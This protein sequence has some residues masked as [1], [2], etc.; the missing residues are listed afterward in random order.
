MHCFLTRPLAGSILCTALALMA[1]MAQGQSG[2]A[3]LS[4]VVSTTTGP[5]EFA[6]IT[7]H[8]AADSAVVK[9][10]FSDP[11]GRFQLLVPT[12][13]RY[14]VSVSQVGY[15]R[16][17]QGPLALGNVPLSPLEF[18]LEAGTA[19]QLRGV[20][21]AGQ[22]PLYERLPDRTVVN[23]E[24]SVLS[25]GNTTLD[26]LGRAPGV[27][28]DAND[29]LALR[30]RQGLLVLVDGKRVPLTGTELAAMLRA[31]PAEQVA[32]VE[33]ITNPPAKYDAQGGAGIIAINLKKDQR[34]GLNGSANA[35]YGRG[36]YGKFSSGLN[37]NYRRKHVNLYGSYAYADRQTWQR[38]TIDRTYLEDNRAA[39]YLEQA[40]TTRGHLQSHTWRGG[41]DVAVSSRTNLGLLVSGLVSRLPSDGQNESRVF[42]G[43][44]QLADIVVAQNQR[45]L[46][47]PNVTANVLLRHLFPKDSLGT[48]VLTVDTDAGRYQLTRTLDLVATPILRSTPTVSRL[49]GDQHGTL[50]LLSAK[51]DYVRNLRRGIRLETGLK[52]SRV[53]SR[54]DVLFER[55]LNGAPT[56]P[57]ATLSNQFRYEEAIRA[58]YLTLSRSRPQLSIS[59]GLRAEYTSTLG[60]QAVSNQQFSR[61]YFQLFPSVN[62]QRP[63]NE[64]HQLA[65]SLSRRL[66]RPTYNQLNPFRSYVDP[67]SY[68]VGNPALWPQISTQAEVTHTFRQQTTTALRYTHTRRPILGVYLLDADGLIAATDVNLSSQDY[69]GLTVASPFAPTAWW[70]LYANAEVF[71]IRFRGRLQGSALPPSQPGAVLSLNSSFTLPQG[72]SAEL[73]GSYNSLERYGYQLVHSF[74]Q[75]GLGVQ[76]T[77]GRATLKLN[78]ADAL[79][80]LPLRAT[81][82]YAPLSESFRSAQDSRVITASLTYKFGNDKVT[83]ARRR[84][85]SA[86]DEKRRAAG[87]Q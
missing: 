26:V 50:T 6:T 42:D 84:A 7:L 18:R 71:Y 33:L 41:A 86:E 25:A 49:L 45:N 8:R 58:G 39:R 46:L 4:G 3:L 2:P 1:G 75:V 80:T 69:W 52:L 5:L 62:L 35:A 14:L 29:N 47:T 23:V 79:Y 17:W 27:T 38:L 20:T 32:T 67:T 81:A 30:G 19:T 61:Q 36:R 15:G 83:A 59:A 16:S 11:A 87:V 65:F 31:L 10:E 37:L 13:G 76:K 73:S 72:W 21:V 34:L 54:N 43:Q 68:R 60:R 9:T 85:G 12:A 57:D 74:G 51:T 66:D 48:P 53:T 24:G 40:N 77:V 28:L 70:K 78:A 63:L 56:Q 22:R 82:R 55:S 64:A 44:H